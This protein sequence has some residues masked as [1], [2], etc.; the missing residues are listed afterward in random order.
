MDA[1]ALRERFTEEEW[2]KLSTAPLTVAALVMQADRSGIFKEMQS[3][4]RYL[5]KAPREV[6][7][8]PLCAAILADQAAALH[9]LRVGAHA[10]SLAQSGGDPYAEVNA[11][12]DILAAKCD[13]DESLAVRQMLFGIARRVA[14][15]AREGSFLG[16]G[17]V[18]ISEKEEAVLNR[19]RFLLRA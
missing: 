7:Q 19:L 14:E 11:V 9:D 4:L 18:H 13:L 3:L 16:F 10:I 17:G 12:L 5:E 2:A 6:R 15:A 8:S 1:A